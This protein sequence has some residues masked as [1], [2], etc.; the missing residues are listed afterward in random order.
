MR[1]L[2]TNN[3]LAGR[4][5]TELYVRDVA[6]GLLKRGH[7]PIAYSTVLGEVADELRAAGIPVLSDLATLTD[8]PD[9]IHGHHHLDA[10]TAM[11]RFPRTPAVYFCHGVLPWE[12]RPPRFPTITQYVAVDDPCAELLRD[13]G[14]PPDEIVVIRNFVNLDRFQRR[15]RLPERPRR[16]LIFSNAARDQ[17]YA[18][19]IR[20]A[21]RERDISVDVAGIASGNS[22]R[23]PEALLHQYDLVFAKARA[24]L[25]ALAVGAAVIACDERGLGPLVTAANYDQL[26][27]LNFGFRCLEALVSLHGVLAAIDRYDPVD[28]DAVT[29]RVRDEAG[30]EQALDRIEALYAHTVAS[31]RTSAVEATASLQ[32]AGAYLRRIA[33]L[34]KERY[35]ADLI[36]FQI[37]SELAVERTERMR[38]DAVVRKTAAERDLARR[39]ADLLRATLEPLRA[40]VADASA[41]LN[42][43]EAELA[44]IYRSHAWPIVRAA[45]RVKHL[46]W[47]R[48]FGRQPQ[49]STR[50]HAFELIY[51]ENRWLADETASGRGSTLAYTEILRRELPGFLSRLGVRRLLDAACG[52]C[53]WRRHVALDLEEYIGVDI[54]P[55]IIERNRRQYSHERWI[56][57]VRDIVEDPLPQS[58]AVLCR[59]CLSHLPNDDIRA[60]I[61]NFKRSGA[62]YLIAT[63]HSPTRVNAEIPIGGWRPLNLTRPPFHLPDPV[64]EIVENPHTGKVLGAWSLAAI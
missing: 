6:V 30:L 41:R 9:V 33:P 57:E 21:C 37:E 31:S 38:L 40:S 56:F 42:R 15:A 46:L 4:A 48:P 19:V 43:R 53:H 39:D 11:L 20:R 26:R 2:F 18:E 58:D 36:R 28:A 62:K 45:F 50:A 61:E 35:G 23:A 24:A 55:A 49:L 59:D 17:G 12:E 64:A 54:V 44:G 22:V 52:D 29:Q 14:I 60:A 7:Q 10:M 5:G 47:T 25:E 16:A 13:E 3:T 27:R 34:V 63:S 8:A 32:S 1:V 51:R